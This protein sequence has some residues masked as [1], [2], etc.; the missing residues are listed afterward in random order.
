MFKIVGLFRRLLKDF[1]IIHKFNNLNQ[2][3]LN[4]NLNHQRHPNQPT[5][6]IQQGSIIG[7]QFTALTTVLTSQIKL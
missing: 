2:D 3:N 4:N 7:D 6:Q 1:K 5:K